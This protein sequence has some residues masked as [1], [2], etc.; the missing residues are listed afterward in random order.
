MTSN[1]FQTGPVGFCSLTV[2]LNPDGHVSHY[3]LEA[4]TPEGKLAAYHSA[5]SLQPFPS[6]R[7]FVRKS[8]EL[9]AW[10]QEA[11]RLTREV[12][13]LQLTIETPTDDGEGL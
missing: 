5:A 9:A 12:Y 11:S 1:T 2:Y 13:G 7:E 6:D 10:V 4:K 8:A 3:E